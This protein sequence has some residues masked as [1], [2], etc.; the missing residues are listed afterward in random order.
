MWRVKI[1]ESANATGHSRRQ[2]GHFQPTR[3]Q[4]L[5]ST[6]KGFRKQAFFCV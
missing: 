1:V 6:L 2:A 5:L 4:P 3:V